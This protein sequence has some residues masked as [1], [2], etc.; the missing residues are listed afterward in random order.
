MGYIPQCAE[1]RAAVHVEDVI[2]LFGERDLN[3]R[4][5]DDLRAFH[6]LCEHP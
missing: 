1:D 5:L 3:G 4:H 6:I 2:Y